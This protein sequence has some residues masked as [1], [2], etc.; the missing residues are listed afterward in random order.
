MI[1][2]NLKHSIFLGIFSFLLG[3]GTLAMAN[4]K[5]VY[6]FSFNKLGGKKLEM[7]EFTGKAI[8]FVNTASRC[9]FTKQYEGLE[10]LYKKYESKGLVVLG[11]PSND[12]GAQEPANNEEI[13]EFC[14]LNYGVSFPMAEKIV[15]KGD[16]K[17]E[18]YKFLTE[19]APTKGEVKWN[20][21]KFLV[22]KK[23]HVVQRYESAV[24][25]MDKKLL[26][27]IEEILQ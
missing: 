20:F 2:M 25:P 5:S 3:G 24:E 18:I 4:Q 23:G 14:K 12:F 27:E 21:E 6:E 16:S 13:A 9:G 26:S 7:K 8:L 15:V 17:N 22:D 10:K 19:N 11:F 1:F